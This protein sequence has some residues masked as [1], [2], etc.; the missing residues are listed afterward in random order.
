MPLLTRRQKAINDFVDRFSSQDDDFDAVLRIT[1]D[2]FTIGQYF[3]T[4]EELNRPLANFAR[5]W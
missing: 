4:D 5:Q 2:Y 1:A 3:I